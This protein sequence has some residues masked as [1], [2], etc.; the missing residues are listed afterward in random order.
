[1]V[2]P[3]F[4]LY[5]PRL[6]R[7]IKYMPVF[8]RIQFPW[9]VRVFSKC[10]RILLTLSVLAFFIGLRYLLT[11]LYESPDSW[12]AICD[13]L[14]PVEWEKLC[15]VPPK[16]RNF[17][18]HWVIWSVFF[19][20]NRTRASSRWGRSLQLYPRIK[21]RLNK[22]RAAASPEAMCNINEK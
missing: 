11:F 22:S 9:A 3:G 15:Y 2:E 4:H 21:M 8:S 20:F 17:K 12:V 16:N 1:M 6:W 13:F 14:W 5:L 18:N 10:I 7:I 19:L